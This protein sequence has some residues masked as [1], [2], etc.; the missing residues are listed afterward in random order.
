MWSVNVPFAA[1]LCVTVS[2]QGVKKGNRLKGPKHETF[3][4]VFFTEIRPVRLGDLGTGEK[5]EIS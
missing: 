3:G 4:S 1:L 5:N 2:N